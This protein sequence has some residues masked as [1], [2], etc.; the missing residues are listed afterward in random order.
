MSVLEY[1]LFKGKAC[2]LFI[3]ATT[4]GWAQSWGSVNML[5]WIL[6]SLIYFSEV[7]N[8]K[9]NLFKFELVL[10][11]S[12][13]L[14]LLSPAL[15]SLPSPLFP[16][17]HSGSLIKNLCMVWS[18]A[19]SLLPPGLAW[20]KG[21]T[22]PSHSRKGY[23]LHPSAQRPLLMDYVW[24]PGIA[25]VSHP[26]KHTKPTLYGVIDSF[27]SWQGSP[28]LQLCWACASTPDLPSKGDVHPEQKVAARAIP[29]L[30]GSMLGL[31]LWKDNTQTLTPWSAS[32][33]PLGGASAV[34]SDLEPC[35]RSAT[36]DS[37]APHTV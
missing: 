27:P 6:K 18:L 9:R 26:L 13:F 37:I 3:F 7:A 19:S 1:E 12:H 35:L 2:V 4:S 16:Q 23:S 25:M 22:E 34:N 28:F 11:S 24:G 14:C 20:S 17:I 29:D 31:D 5:N 33:F 10:P 36:S 30:L 21:C 15:P 8:F 32:L